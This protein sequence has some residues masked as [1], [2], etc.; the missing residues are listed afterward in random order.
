MQ[1][2][3]MEKATLGQKPQCLFASVI[4]S[5]LWLCMEGSVSFSRLENSLLNKSNKNLWVS[6]RNNQCDT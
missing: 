4:K 3:D 6:L 1:I 2:I 5:I